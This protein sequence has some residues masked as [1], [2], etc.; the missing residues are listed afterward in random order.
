MAVTNSWQTKSARVALCRGERGLEMIRESCP[1]TQIWV[2]LSGEW[3]EAGD[4]GRRRIQPYETRRY[5]PRQPCRRIVDSDSRAV[6]IELLGFAGA[7]LLSARQTRL[8]WRIAHRALS[9]GFDQLQLDEAAAQF[10][11]EAIPNFGWSDWL[12][13][14]T[15]IIHEEFRDPLTLSELASRVGISSN[16]LSSAFHAMHAVPIPKYVR[17][18]RLED[19]LRRMGTESAPWLTAGF[20]DA[21]H[22]WRACQTDLGL[23]PKQLQELNR[24]IVQDN[25]RGEAE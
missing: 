12:D 21:S 10:E 8:A 4:G 16:H 5:A 9:G 24:K 11:D 18:L 13:R 22:F 17:R 1:N 2:L 23:T 3:W 14:A 6:S 19:A 7:P 25:V 15:E 20:Y